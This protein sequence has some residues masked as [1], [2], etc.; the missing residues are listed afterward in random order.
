MSYYDPK[1]QWASKYAYNTTTSTP[2]QPSSS[3]SSLPVTN[4][5]AYTQRSTYSHTHPHQTQQPQQLPHGAA[6]AYQPASYQQNSYYS[7]GALG[8][9]PSSASMHAASSS[10]SLYPSTMSSMKYGTDY[11][12]SGSV[13][14]YNTTA[15]TTTATSGTADATSATGSNS[16]AQTSQPPAGKKKKTVI[17]AA[18]GELW[19]DPTM[20]EWDESMY[21]SSCHYCEV[22]MKLENIIYLFFI[23]I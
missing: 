9:G 22:L 14:P 11:S 7:T 23:S 15:T 16:V 18:G 5:Y 19:E 10:T 17:R 20:L 13:I 1:T 2:A 4:P 21:I 6:T 8:Y 12:I 3:S